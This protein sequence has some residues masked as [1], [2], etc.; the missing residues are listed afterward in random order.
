MK[1]LIPVA[2]LLALLAASSATAILSPPVEVRIQPLDELPE[3]GESITVSFE[4][5]S[6]IAGRVTEID[7]VSHASYFR[8]DTKTNQI[9][10]WAITDYTAP[11]TLFLTPEQTATIDLTMICND[12]SEMIRIAFTF[13]GQRIQRDF[14][15]VPLGQR[16]GRDWML[17]TVPGSTKE[18]HGRDESR[19]IPD[20][21][22][23]PL[24]DII[25]LD[26]VIPLAED[27]ATDKYVFTLMGKIVYVRS[28]GLQDGADG[29]TVTAFERLPPFS[30]ERGSQVTDADGNFDFQVSANSNPNI[31]FKVTT[32]NAA[33]AV[34]FPGAP[35]VSYQFTTPTYWDESG[36]TIHYGTLKPDDMSIAPA[37][38]IQ[39]SLTRAWRF[40]MEE[41]YAISS[42]SARWPTGEGAS[43]QGWNH[44][45]N[46]GSNRSWN[47]RTHCHEFGHH[48]NGEYGAHLSN[49][50]DYC[51]PGGYADD[52]GD[53]GH[54]LW[55]PENDGVAWSEGF[56]DWF[57]SVNLIKIQNEY[58]STVAE[59]DIETLIGCTENANAIGSFLTTE[60]LLAALLFDVSDADQDTD[61]AGFN[62]AQDRIMWGNDAVLALV[63][64]YEPV[65]SVGF[66]N[67]LLAEY[68][69][70]RQKIWTTA[71]NNRYNFDTTD[72]PA[73]S[74]LYSTSHQ[75]SGDSPDYTVDLWW[76]D[77]TDADSGVDYYTI[78]IADNANFTG[79][80]VDFYDAQPGGTFTSP[81]L[82]PGVY[83]F[84][85]YT[86]DK[87]GNGNGAAYFGPVTIRPA[88]PPD[89]VPAHGTWP[90]P[91]LAKSYTGAP[92]TI[93]PF[94]FGN[95]QNTYYSVSVGN[96]GELDAA[97]T[98]H[99][100]LY[101]DGLFTYVLN[102]TDLDAFG[103]V[104]VRDVGPDL[105]RGGRHNLTFIADA[106]EERSE[107]NEDNNW[108]NHQYIWSGMGL[109][110]T[111]RT[112]GKAPDAWGGFE[113]TN[114]FLSPNC[115]GF[116]FSTQISEFRGVVMVPAGAAG[117]F[118]DHDLR[119]FPISTDSGTGFNSL[120]AH[121]NSFRPTGCLDAIF[122]VN[123]LTTGTYFNVGAFR[124][125]DSGWGF[126]I[127]RVDSVNISPQVTHP[128]TI[129]NGD[130]L[131]IYRVSIGGGLPGG[132]FATL[133]V[134]SDPA[135][136]LLHAAVF[137]MATAH[138]GLDDPLVTGQSD[139][140][141]E[142]VLNF[143]QIN[144]R[145]LIAVWQDPKDSPIPAGDIA[146]TLWIGQTP[147]DLL[148]TTAAGWLAP[149]VPTDGAPGSPGSV[150]APVQLQGN[151]A[152][153]YL[154]FGVR[155]ESVTMVGNFRKL[156][157]LD[158][159][160]LTGTEIGQL[161][162]YANHL[163]NYGHVFS[164]QG[165]R[166]SLSGMADNQF[167]V[168]ESS[169]TN[170]F[171]GRQ[172]VWSPLQLAGPGGWVVRSA[173]PAA[174]GGWDHVLVSPPAFP[175]D[176]PVYVN[177]DGLRT[178]L[179][180]I[181]GNDGWWQ[182][183]AIRAHGS[184]DYD[185]RLHDAITS[186]D[187]G[188][189]NFN[190]LSNWSGMAVDYVLV[191]F[192]NTAPQ[193]FDVG[194][195]NSHGSKNYWLQTEE[196]TFLGTNPTG[197]HGT[198]SLAADAL[199]NLHE[200]Y[201]DTGPVLVRLLNVAGSVDWGMSLHLGNAA[202]HSKTTALADGTISW[203]EGG[204]G[205]EELISADVPVAGYYCIAVWR[206]DNAASG[207][208][209][210]D[211][212]FDNVSGVDTDVPR[213]TSSGLV[214]VHPNPFN[215]T[216][217]I[218]FELAKENTV[219]LSV[220]DVRGARVRELVHQSLPPGRHAAVWNGQNDRGERVSSGTYFVQ[221]NVGEVRET[222]SISLVK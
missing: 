68:P 1:R 26:N 61:P 29:V 212:E 95:I 74:A 202:Y 37:L 154:N 171:F 11:T 104:S 24:A 128:I 127:R 42:V 79:P 117:D 31:F 136:G 188:F 16:D 122:A 18:P 222:R 2:L 189:K 139:A 88:T 93:S 199:L 148:P 167:D 19:A 38:H 23:D 126:K 135:D 82:Q 137:D 170:N 66:V 105:V 146:A 89:L 149:V 32:S 162:G 84:R 115:D 78:T 48:F 71:A 169:E 221:L 87:A 75:T 43:Y 54:R 40:L 15:L 156:V 153:T 108:Y 56:A 73:V 91:V 142:I 216:T 101:V 50:A 77:V 92:W 172:W 102:T 179:P 180:G 41:N 160:G 86:W 30:Y 182:T 141:G 197:I 195:V 220:F 118:G 166:H 49:S 97:G 129:A 192:R 218:D 213:P 13:E 207:A 10:E 69:T 143:D 58:G 215:P 25:G 209:Q 144:G 76:N 183:V 36:P 181:S 204:E 8:D 20:L 159:V 176:S 193:Q 177:C 17:H 130:Y 186:V 57:A 99:H 63:N 185:L 211:L 55:C 174:E 155:N 34:D 116:S 107:S 133:R 3:V 196:S 198:Y 6:P 113:T 39:T 44:I 46:V 70:H 123:D 14:F 28:D 27:S 152:S 175:G 22:P 190:V 158:G 60:G 90:H 52:D 145:H 9:H 131:N 96:G 80:N 45:I 81:A 184:A 208:G 5:T 138:A 214:S 161:S 132:D 121:A 106:D 4:I 219:V 83:W 111:W 164:V 151:I 112:R 103:Q 124:Y 119:S 64:Q 187:A 67:A 109:N 140:N 59:T 163:S 217:T 125:D 21:K 134:N 147:P 210:Y 191:N 168:T 114:I 165:G 110:Q 150:P 7:F 173:P 94:L 72:P 33:V 85:I 53:C 194:V 203:L 47:E 178:T 51:N 12:P 120:N 65:T 205:G 157:Y 98:Q 206:D 201:L 35:G 200:V 100:R 62:N